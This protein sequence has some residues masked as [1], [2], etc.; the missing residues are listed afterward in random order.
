MLRSCFTVLFLAGAAG[1]PQSLGSAAERIRVE[2]ESTID[3]TRQP[4]YVI[5]PDGFDARGKKRPLL[6]SLHSWSRDLEHRQT[7]L[8]AE[9]NRL[10]WIYLY[11]NFRGPNNHP[12]ACGSLKAQQDILDAV[13][14]ARDTYPVDDQ[15][16]Y[17]TGVSGGGHMTMLM[18]GRHPE[19]WAAASAW[20]GIS[21][22]ATWHEFHNRTRS[23]YALMMEN[24]C[25]GKPGDSP[26]VDAEYRARSPITYMHRAVD[27]PVD[28]AAGV[29]DGHSGSV[30][31]SQALRAFNAIA[32]AA[33]AT[34]I[35]QD[36]I[37][38]ISR[39][40]GRLAQKLE[41]DRVRDESLGR[42]IHLRR[43]A[44]KSRVT[45]FEGGHEGNSEAAINWLG[46]HVK[47]P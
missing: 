35:S 28:I 44:G 23:N 21:D 26:S 9:A 2:V 40:A 5:L 33:K 46:R 38:Q 10:G 8:E 27:V 22:L 1:L 45:V 20:V 12:D 30:P 29:H 4:S 13:D 47:S 31:I 36:E 25:G 6:V 41:S 34:P 14:W 37:R 16:I 32:V 11:P 17:L 18:V 7:T 3:G 24:S 43:H 42:E 15:R 39:P 19:I